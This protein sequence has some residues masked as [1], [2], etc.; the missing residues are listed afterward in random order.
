MG[1]FHY[2]SFKELKP[3]HSWIMYH[4]TNLNIANY[5]LPT[6]YIT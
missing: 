5:D 2:I 4:K 3:V 6:E 1:K